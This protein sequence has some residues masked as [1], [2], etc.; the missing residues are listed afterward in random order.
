M[1]GR[2][3]VLAISSSDHANICVAHLYHA[4][5]YVEYV[6]YKNTRQI[7][8]LMQLKEPEMSRCYN[9]HLHVV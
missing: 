5:E 1:V 2:Q 6:Q 9:C 4:L 8:S 3:V 7:S